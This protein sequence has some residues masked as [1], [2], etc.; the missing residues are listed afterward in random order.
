MSFRPFLPTVTDFSSCENVW[1]SMGTS[2]SWLSTT[3]PPSREKIH[4]TDFKIITHN[5]FEM[6]FLPDLSALPLFFLYPLIRSWGS[7]RIRA[8][9]DC[10][11][12][13]WGASVAGHRLLCPWQHS[14]QTV[15]QSVHHCLWT[16]ASC[17][18]FA[19][20]W[21]DKQ[22]TQGKQ[23]SPSKLWFSAHVDSYFLNFYTFTA[24][25]SLVL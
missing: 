18:N 4:S 5:G 21:V 2:W 8:E 13:T 12:A 22:G 11:R 1:H 3:L 9:E 25:Q 6:F 23:K 20:W 19:D 14:G 7:W 10:V 15:P 24:H 16:A 17:E